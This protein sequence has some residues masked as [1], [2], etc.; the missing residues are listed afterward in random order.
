MAGPAASSP[1][2][3]LTS[4]VSLCLESLA[5]NPT[6][7]DMAAVRALPSEC[8]VALFDVRFSALFT[9]QAFYYSTKT[10]NGLII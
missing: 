10:N 7:L 4:L 8:A 6:Q 2:Q 9:V 5:S 3:H 1:Q